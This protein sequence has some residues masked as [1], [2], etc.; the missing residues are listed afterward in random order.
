M[1]VIH[2]QLLPCIGMLKCPSRLINQPDLCPG[3]ATSFWCLYDMCWG[4]CVALTLGVGYDAVET[5]GTVYRDARLVPR[6]P[7][8]HHSGPYVETSDGLPADG[9]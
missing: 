7:C 8:T 3:V 2:E 9:S 4:P 6:E 5:R 1:F